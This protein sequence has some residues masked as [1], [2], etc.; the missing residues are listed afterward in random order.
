VVATEDG[1]ENLV[2]QVYQVLCPVNRERGRHGD[3][4]GVPE[5]IYSALHLQPQP[6]K[7]TL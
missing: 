2:S 3:A 6:R 4:V 1:S 7:L 5:V